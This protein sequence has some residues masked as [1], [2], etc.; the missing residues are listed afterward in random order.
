MAVYI[1]SS[2][3]DSYV[4][5][6]RALRTNAGTDD[7]GGVNIDRGA[8]FDNGKRSTVTDCRFELCGGP[9]IEAFTGATG[10]FYE[11]NLIRNPCQLTTINPYG[12]FVNTSSAINAD[13]HNNRFVVTDGLCTTA[14][15]ASNGN[16]TGFFTGNNARGITTPWNFGGAIMHQSNS[17]GPLLSVGQSGPTLT[18]ASGVI[19]VTSLLSPSFMIAGEGGAADDLVTINGGVSGQTIFMRRATG[20]N[21]TLKHGTG[22]IFL[23]GSADKIL[24]GSFD[25]I[26]LIKNGVNWIGSYFADV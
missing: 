7:L 22:N 13:I 17:P 25:T 23:P 9:A 5:N 24:G 19:D 6:V 12:I 18:I 3:E 1:D 11:R 4:K 26:Q 15:R 14:I 8:I 2:A 16:T 10:F 20:V 21:I